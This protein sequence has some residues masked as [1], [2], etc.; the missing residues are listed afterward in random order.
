MHSDALNAQDRE[1]RR[2]A[3]ALHDETLQGLGGLR[4]LLSTARG[5]GDP[6][7]LA[8]AVDQALELLTE[9]IHKLRHLIIDLRPAELDDIGLEAAIEKLGRRTA[10]F[11][12]PKVTTEVRLSYEAGTSANRLTPEIETA[13]YRVVQE[14]L[15]NAVK[16]ADASAVHVRVSDA[17]DELDVQVADDGRGFNGRPAD[18][19]FGIVGMRERA[20]LISGTLTVTTSSEGTTVRLAAPARRR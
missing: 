18:E 2:W 4:I 6:D 7:H 1:R 11:G 10:V 5:R 19:R 12:G 15:T 16:H 17:N 8:A 20:A 14:A 13:A 3:R 9:E